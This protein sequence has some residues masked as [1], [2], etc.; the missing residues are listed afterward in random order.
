[1]AIEVRVATDPMQQFDEALPLLEANWEESAIPIPFI[2]EDARKFYNHLAGQGTLLTGTGRLFAV[3]A[4][5]ND[6]LVGYCIA[7]IAPHPL[8]HVVQIAHV[9]GIYLKPKYRKGCAGAGM[10][11][12]IKEL[13]KEREAYAIN[14]HAPTGS[15]FA[16]T[17]ASRFDPLNEY[18]MERVR[19]D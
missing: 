17:L 3:G 9:N 1:M 6:E 7:N 5:D 15:V 11:A 4:Y 18:F 2:A 16:K 8:N 10:M 12:A 14:W 13:A 19:Y